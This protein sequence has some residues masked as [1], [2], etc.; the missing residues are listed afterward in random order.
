MA[1]RLSKLA[2]GGH[3][4]RTLDAPAV[5]EKSKPGGLTQVRVERMVPTPPWKLKYSDFVGRT[6]TV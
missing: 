2:T 5:V 1:K 6:L 3:S 4:K